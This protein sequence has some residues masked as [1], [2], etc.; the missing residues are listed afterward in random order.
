MVSLLSHPA[1]TS[2]DL[3]VHGCGGLRTHLFGL[4]PSSSSSVGLSRN[5]VL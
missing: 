1:Q 3:W 2:L 4:G 5:W